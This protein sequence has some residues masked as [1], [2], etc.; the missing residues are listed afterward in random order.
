M[1]N[2]LPLTSVIDQLLEKNIAFAC[3]FNQ[4][5]NRLEIVIG[6]STDI[7][8]FDRFDQLNGE[9]GFVFAPYRITEKCPVILLKPTIYLEDFNSSDQLDFSNIAPI[10]EASKTDEHCDG[11]TKEEYI[12]TI[13]ETVSA[14]REGDLSKVIIS[15][16]I[17]VKRPSKSLAD[18]FFQLHDQTPNAFTYLV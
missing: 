4:M 15:R 1:E 7:K 11:C 10:I 5:D 3:W 14:I 18:I 2:N 8:R 9:A 16:K 17:P 12:Q 6:N 13:E